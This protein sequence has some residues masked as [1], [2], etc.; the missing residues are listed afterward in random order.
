LLGKAKAIDHS[1]S[2]LINHE[3]PEIIER[4]WL[5]LC[6]DDPA[7]KFLEVIKQLVLSM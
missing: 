6:K 1:P 3:S 5:V 4:G 2:E 7:G